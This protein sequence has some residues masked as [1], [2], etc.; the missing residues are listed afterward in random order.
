MFGMLCSNL[1]CTS[2]LVDSI[3]G[4][5]R[6][7][8][9]I[10]MHYFRDVE[11]QYKPDRTFITQADLEIEHFLYQRIRSAC[12]AHLL[13]GEEESPRKALQRFS[14][15]W[16]IDPIDGTT[17][18]VQ[19]LPGWG[20]S[21]GLLHQGQPCFGAFY[22]PLLNDM[23]YTSD[24]ALIRCNN[25][26]LRQPIR[27]DWGAK[28]FLAINATAHSDFR[29]KVQRTRALGSIGASLVYTA[30]GA[31]VAAFIPKA[32][33]WDLVAGA[34]IL[35]QAGGEL[36]YLSGRLIDYEELLDGRLAPEPIIAAHPNLQAEL[37]TLISPYQ[38]LNQL[39]M[40]K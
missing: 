30:R 38:E 1:Q 15:I 11:P 33:L 19:G 25:R 28:G 32:Y 5:M 27:L 22:M 39:A 13:I 10:A 34:A 17:A 40:N 24:Q 6:Q 16:A 9:Q 23:T 37:R 29:I 4:W 14:D 35:I 21:I 26:Y 2:N 31:A 36:R 12:P 3:I 8:G 20:V 18:F 7:A